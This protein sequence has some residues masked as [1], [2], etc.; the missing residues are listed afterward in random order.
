MV[1]V[2]DDKMSQQQQQQP[3]Q[4]PVVLLSS[5]TV[6]SLIGDN[7]RSDC[8]CWTPQTDLRAAKTKKKKMELKVHATSINILTSSSAPPEIDIDPLN[9]VK[10][11]F[12]QYS[13]I[14][15]SWSPAQLR[16]WARLL[17]T[18]FCRMEQGWFFQ[19]WLATVPHHDDQCSWWWRSASLTCGSQWVLQPRLSFRFIEIFF[20]N[21]TME[22]QFHS[23]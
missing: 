13:R 10:H 6:V 15:W 20:Q 19:L 14:V 18:G 1:C 3:A 21:G 16:D 11:I 23:Y 17:L 8:C 7:R 9:A 5:Y 12:H 2:I 4:W 22:W